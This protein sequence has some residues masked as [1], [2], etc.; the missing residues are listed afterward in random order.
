MARDYDPREWAGHL[1]DGVDP[2][3]IPYNQSCV[4]AV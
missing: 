1:P 4:Y 3:I 2:L